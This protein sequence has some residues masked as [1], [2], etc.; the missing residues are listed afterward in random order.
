[1]NDGEGEKRKTVLFLCEEPSFGNAFIC[2]FNRA[3]GGI[4]SV[5]FLRC[6]A[7]SDFINH[8]QYQMRQKQKCKISRN[9]EECINE[10]SNAAK[11]AAVRRDDFKIIQNDLDNG[12]DEMM[13]QQN[14]RDIG[15]AVRYNVKNQIYAVNNAYGNQ[16]TICPSVEKKEADDD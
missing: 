7:Y 1:M 15:F 6:S 11:K 4:R 13:Q 8:K 2:F 12:T 14:P 10:L 5:L 16:K 3:A 9:K